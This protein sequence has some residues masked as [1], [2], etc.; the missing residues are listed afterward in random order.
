ME[1][2][3]SDCGECGRAPWP[4]HCAVSQKMRSCSPA[5]IWCWALQQQL[6][7]TVDTGP[8]VDDRN[9]KDAN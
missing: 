2:A 6:A 4:S 9:K 3:K 8:P 1:G 7:M 5:G